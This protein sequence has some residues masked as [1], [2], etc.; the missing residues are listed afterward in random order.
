MTV[1]DVISFCVPMCRAPRLHGLRLGQ[2]RLLVL[3]S[4]EG[5]GVV[6]PDASRNYLSFCETPSSPLSLLG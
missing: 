2:A 5:I 3:I 4:A 1:L 6:T